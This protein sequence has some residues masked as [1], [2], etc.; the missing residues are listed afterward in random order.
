M[1]NE[2]SE[3]PTGGEL[4]A[5]VIE[6]IREF[7]DWLEIY[8]SVGPFDGPDSQKETRRQIEEIQARRE[9]LVA[10][11]SAHPECRLE[12]QC[13]LEGALRRAR[14]RRLLVLRTNVA[15]WN[16]GSEAYRRGESGDNVLSWLEWR[17]QPPGIKESWQSEIGRLEVELSL[18]AAK[19]SGNA[20]AGV[21][22]R[23]SEPIRDR[24]AWLLTIPKRGTDGKKI[25]HFEAGLR[26]LEEVEVWGYAANAR[27]GK[28]K[29][30]PLAKALGINR[31]SL[32][33]GFQN[34]KRAMSKARTLGKAQC[35]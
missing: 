11:N 1:E 17:D 32:T 16:A 18:P 33:E 27:T 5:A 4:M 25:K 8:P 29:F 14:L 6:A 3:Q 15:T 23:R 7:E 31:K 19:G 28:P 34:I 30:A 13:D 12:V 10:Y 26:G 22:Q 35:K 9:K 21:W 24:E 2:S 20:K